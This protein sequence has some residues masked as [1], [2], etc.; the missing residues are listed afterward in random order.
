M[1]LLRSISLKETKNASSERKAMC[2]STGL[3]SVLNDLSP[4]GDFNIACSDM[5]IAIRC[6][7]APALDD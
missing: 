7:V 6:N 2:V 5:V 4:V 1:G 3:K